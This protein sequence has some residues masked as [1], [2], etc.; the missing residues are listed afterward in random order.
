MKA[1]VWTH[2]RN[3]MKR[4]LTLQLRLALSTTGILIFFS[5]GLIIFINLATSLALPEPLSAVAFPADTRFDISFPTPTPYPEF[6]PWEVT[7]TDTTQNIV[8][9]RLRIISL[10]GF[11]LVIVLGGV[12]VYFLAGRQLAS[13]R[14]F[15]QTA[16]YISAENLDTRLQTEGPEDELSEL[17]KTFNNMMDR[18]EAA[19]LQQ[20]RF[21][22]DAA[23]ELRTPLAIL[24]TN[25]EVIRSNPT[26]SVSDYQEMSRILERTIC[27]LEEVV[28]DLLMLALGEKEMA[29]EAIILGPL[30]GPVDI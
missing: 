8:F 15:A 6:V 17:A 28:A 3:W 29:R 25:L 18:L 5:L 19:F 13:I 10:A 1:F 20:S 14:L 30:L 4:R 11:G 26:A 9:E 21:V 27:R 22:A 12:T 24:R 2:L 16:R 7:T 23:H